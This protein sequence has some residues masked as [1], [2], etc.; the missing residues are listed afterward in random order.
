[1]SVGLEHYLVL[2]SI[3]FCIGIYGAL[4]KRNAVVILMCVEIM[5]NAVNIALVTFSRFLVEDTVLLDGHV[6]VIFVLVVAAAEATV[7]LAI[8]MAIYRSRRSVDP[9]KIDMMKG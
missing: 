9:D 8:I 6:F 4:A 1:M 7:G 3:L 2:S 5:L